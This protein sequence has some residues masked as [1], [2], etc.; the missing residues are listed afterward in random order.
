[1]GFM[2]GRK[3]DAKSKLPYAFL[4]RSGEPVAFSG[5]W[6]GWKDPATGERSQSYAIITTELNELTATSTRPKPS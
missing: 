5:V 2:N 1:M 4:L 3:S 6:D